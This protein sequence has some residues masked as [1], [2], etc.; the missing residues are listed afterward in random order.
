MG[1]PSTAARRSP[2]T[3]PVWSSA[4]LAPERLPPDVLVGGEPGSR[5][6]DARHG[7][8]GLGAAEAVLLPDALVG[9]PHAGPAGVDEV[10]HR[11]RATCAEVLLDDQRRGVEG[12][13][14]SVRP[15]D[16]EEHLGHGSTV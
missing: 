6:L 13:R 9:D 2:V 1:E 4:L 12:L 16:V 7:R 5:L 8:D 11:V 10:A 15:A 3:G 14:G